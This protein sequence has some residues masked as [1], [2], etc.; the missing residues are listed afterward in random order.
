M[1]TTSR[2]R[3][4]M[5]TALLTLVSCSGGDSAPTQQRPTSPTPGPLARVVVTTSV[6]QIEVSETA[7]AASSG[8]DAQ[9]IPVTIG[10]TVFS[11]GTPTVA[12]VTP[13]GLIIGVSPGLARILADVDGQRGETTITVVPI[14]VAAVTIA[15]GPMTL[16]PGATQEV[17]ATALDRR[18]LVLQGRPVAWS[19]S[20]QTVA[21]VSASGVVSAVAGG[22][23][24]ISANADG[25][26]SRIAVTVST[27]EGRVTRIAVAPTNAAMRVGDRLPFNF[28]LSD[29][30]GRDATGR[31]FRW[32]VS[33]TSVIS[34]S[35][36]GLVIARAPGSATVRVS[37]EGQTGTASVTVSPATDFGLR[38]IVLRPEA[39][40]AIIDTLRP[41]IDVRSASAVNGVTVILN[42]K[43]T[44]LRL[45]P[46][47]AGFNTF[48]FWQGPIDIQDLPIGRNVAIVQTTDAAGRRGQA[49]FVFNRE[50]RD[51]GGG[52]RPPTPVK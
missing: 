35:D 16:V 46:F 23:A 50:F 17:I 26:I 20:D 34:V 6:P 31:V 32:S 12:T 40:A 10:P 7:I 19:S 3:A 25:V 36:N 42:G 8:F 21:R 18:G 11:S 22:V 45:L 41:V 39:D 52:T 2:T 48:F 13:S 14:P 51:G 37:S 49:E 29:S 30:L 24:T 9:S 43:G 5:A 15:P 28:A 1:V 4:V 47:S 33:D 44:A 27:T 38:I